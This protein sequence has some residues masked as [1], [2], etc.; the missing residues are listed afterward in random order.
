MGLEQDRE[1]GFQAERILKD[2]LFQQAWAEINNRIMEQWRQS[3]PDQ[4]AERER[5]HTEIRVLEALKRT[6]EAHI[7]TGKY[8]VQKIEQDKKRSRNAQ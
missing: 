5:I 7:S 2:E 4:T 3:K 8:A 1:R 6:F